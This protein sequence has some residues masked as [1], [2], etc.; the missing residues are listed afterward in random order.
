M[1]TSQIMK[2]DFN[3]GQVEQR[4]D[5]GYFNANSLVALFAAQTGQYK[6][7]TNFLRNEST[8]SFLEELSQHTGLPESQLF[9]RPHKQSCWMH[10]LLF[11][12]FA[13]WLSPEFKLKVLVWLHDNL[14]L[15]RNQAGDHYNEMTMTISETFE[16]WAGKKANALVFIREANYLNSLLGISSN[17]RNELSEKQLADLN[18]LQLANIRLM[19]SG[20]G[21]V[22]RHEQLRIF[23]DLIK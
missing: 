23:Y 10:P 2:R 19:K 8:K 20:M 17:M 15:F 6:H 11:L 22:K 16:K 5:D 4:T 7:P 3:N 1:K 9:T 12:D 21:K 14:I 18:A 13:M